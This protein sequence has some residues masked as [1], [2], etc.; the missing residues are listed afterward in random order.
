MPATTEAEKQAIVRTAQGI[1]RRHLDRYWN[2]AC[3]I[4]GLRDRELLRASHIKPWAASSDYERVDV[5]NGLLLSTLW[6]AA[7]DQGLISFRDDGSLRVS[8]KLSQRAIDALT[9]GRAVTVTRDR[10]PC[11]VPARAPIAAWLQS[12]TDL[13]SRSLSLAP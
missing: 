7:F 3:A 9:E 2:N 12:R 4:T 6:D 5:Y 8:P 13:R 10:R 11:D 1:F